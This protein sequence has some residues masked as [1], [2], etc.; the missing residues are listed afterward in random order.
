MSVAECQATHEGVTR[1]MSD[2][3]MSVTQIVNTLLGEPNPGSLERSKGLVD[4]VKE[5]KAGMKSRWSPKDKAAIVISL[6][7]AISAIIVAV[8]K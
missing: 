1:Q 7:T 8:F 2:L 3:Q 6:V 4:Y 5:I